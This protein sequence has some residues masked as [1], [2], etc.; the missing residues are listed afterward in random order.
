MTKANQIVTVE[1]KNGVPEAVC[2]GCEQMQLHPGKSAEAA[3]EWARTHAEQC[4][5]R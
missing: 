3:K 5:G 1:S 4:T 2:S